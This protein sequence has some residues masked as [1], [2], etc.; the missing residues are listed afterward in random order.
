MTAIGDLHCRRVLVAIAGDD[1]DA[2]ALL[3][4]AARIADA[5]TA[6]YVM[7]HFDHPREMTELA[8]RGHEIR[9]LDDPYGNMQAIAWDR[10]SGVVTAASDPG[11][12][13]APNGAKLYR[14]SSL[15]R[16][17]PGH[18]ARR[19]RFETNQDTSGCRTACRQVTLGQKVTVTGGA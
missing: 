2:E 15:S 5:G 17:C 18:A 11:A 8:R 14:G 7:A 13:C 10:R 16:D 3:D 4:L 1:L 19:A 12:S 6:L 9:L